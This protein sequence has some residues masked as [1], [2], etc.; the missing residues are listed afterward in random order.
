MEY[1]QMAKQMIDL[2]KLSFDNWYSA[3]CLMQ[4]QASSMLDQTPWMPAE[5]RQSIQNWI[6]SYQQERDRFKS[7]VHQSLDEL[8]KY[9]SEGVE[10]SRRAASRFRKTTEKQSAI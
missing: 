10:E 5:G 6:N 8:E 2:Q 1:S 4:D 7:Y 3:V 9:I